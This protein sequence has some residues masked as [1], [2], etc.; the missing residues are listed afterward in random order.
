MKSV[1]FKA[2]FLVTL[3]FSCVVPPLSAETVMTVPP[4]PKIAFTEPV[5]TEEIPGISEQTL[6]QAKEQENG[7]YTDMVRTSNSGG[8]I[9]TAWDKTSPREGSHVYR[10]C[11][12]CVYKVRTR[13]FM[14]TTIVL[15][16]HLEV[17]SADLGDNTG[18]KVEVRGQNILAVR[19]TTYGI[20]T[21]LN[22]YTTTGEVYAFYVR[23]EGF[24][25]KNVPDLL[26]KIIG[27][28]VTMVEG[29]R[30]QQKVKESSDA[31]IVKAVKDLKKPEEP[32]D[33]IRKIEFNPAKLHGFNNYKLWGDEELKPAVVFRDDQFTYLQFDDRWDS[34]ELPTAYVVIDKIDEMVNTRIEGNTYIIESTAKLISLKS[35]EKYLCIEYKGE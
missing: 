12:D 25:S 2:I 24:N 22:V 11:G 21:N 18:F 34:L 10:E 13:E 30:R 28:P 4:K 31:D 32:S 8:Q 5:K 7:D 6:K 27:E 35:G 16:S 33:F 29:W 14:T 17:K 3:F 23:A 20:D 26:V 15:P 9:Q 19:P 1:I